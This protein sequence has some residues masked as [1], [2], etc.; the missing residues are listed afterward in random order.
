M[1][2]VVVGGEDDRTT[3]ASVDDLDAT[4]E[5][6]RVVD[7]TEG[8]FVAVEDDPAVE[9]R[10]CEYQSFTKVHVEPDAPTRRAKCQHLLH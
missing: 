2:R 9:A 5:L 6:L 7:V 3:V 1:A 4:A 10:H 8:V